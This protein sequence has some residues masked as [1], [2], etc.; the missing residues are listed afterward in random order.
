MAAIAEQLSAELAPFGLDITIPFHAEFYNNV[1]NPGKHPLPSLSLSGETL[2]LL[3]ANSIHIW[4]PFT[5]HLKENPTAV[6]SRNPLDEYTR[7]CIHACLNKVVDAS[8]PRDVHFAH[9]LKRIIAFQKLRHMVGE[10]YYNRDMAISCHP[11]YGPW[12]AS[13]AV[14]TIGVDASDVPYD[15]FV[16]LEDP[17]PEGEEKVKECMAE[18]FAALGEAKPKESGPRELYRHL[19][20]ARD[21]ATTEEQKA[22]RYT[23]DQIDYHMTKNKDLLRKYLK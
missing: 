22:Y 11:V 1:V 14:I 23:E 7:D 9:D 13:R 20:A 17:F 5:Q 6:D 19:V 12:N 10:S 4:K 21:S 8:V 16:E 3:V 2:C 18:Y 15:S